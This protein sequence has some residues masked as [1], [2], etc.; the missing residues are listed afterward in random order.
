M[1]VFSSSFIQCLAIALAASSSVS[2]APASTIKPRFHVLKHSL[3]STPEGWSKVAPAEAAST[4]TLQFA[5]K[6]YGF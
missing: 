2:A 5:L 4:V 6:Q 1:M 3:P